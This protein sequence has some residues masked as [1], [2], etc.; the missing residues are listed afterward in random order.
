MKSEISAQF[1]SDIK[2]VWNTVTNNEDYSWRS[3][4]EKIEILDHG[5]AFVEHSKNNIKTTFYI[6]KKVK[7]DSYEFKMENK[8]FFG[9][10]KGCFMET[11]DGGTKII[12][13]EEIFMKNL[14]MR[15][16]SHLFMNPSKMQSSYINDLRIKLGEFDESNA[17]D[18]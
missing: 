4:I 15:V 12:F 2:K 18:V 13:T 3:D 9:T 16:L 17:V 7:Y 8:N 6:T 11:K 5:D 1:N 10:W 14:I